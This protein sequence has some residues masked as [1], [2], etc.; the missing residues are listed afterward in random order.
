MERRVGPGHPRMYLSFVFSLVRHLFSSGRGDVSFFF[1]T[2]GWG[3]EYDRQGR[4]GAREKV[5]Y[6]NSYCRLL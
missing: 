5:V 6:V 2:G 4:F 3:P 1:L